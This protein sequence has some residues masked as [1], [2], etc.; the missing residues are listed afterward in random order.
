MCFLLFFSPPIVVTLGSVSLVFPVGNIWHLVNLFYS[1]VAWQPC[2][3]L[4]KRG[5]VL[6]QRL[7]FAHHKNM[8]SSLGIRAL[9]KVVNYC[10][11]KVAEHISE[12]NISGYFSIPRKRNIYS[13]N[14]YWNVLLNPRLIEIRAATIE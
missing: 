7:T 2:R 14:S 1:I 12:K 4:E 8:L 6:K 3:K 10:Y 9:N 5:D 11:I 13:Q